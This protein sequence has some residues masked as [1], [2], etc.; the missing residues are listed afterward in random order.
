M[1]PLNQPPQ[2]Q[3]SNQPDQFEILRRRARQRANTQ[4]QQQQEALKRR[5]A[6]IGRLNSGAAIK[7]GQIAAQQAARQ[8]EET[9]QN[10][11][12]AEARENQRRR[13]LQQGRDFQAGETQKQR[14]FA[15]TEAGKGREFQTGIL[16]QQQDFAGGEAQKNRDFQQALADKEFQAQAAQNFLQNQINLGELAIARGI[17]L[18][19]P[20]SL[21]A[22]R[23]QLNTFAPFIRDLGFDRSGNPIIKGR[24]E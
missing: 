17:D 23:D 1:P 4:G 7:T 20:G 10:I 5:F 18:R 22:F 19:S 16:T 9:A 11:D 8:G 2:G 21:A 3:P 24:G 15:S 6:S 12:V 14:D 13:E